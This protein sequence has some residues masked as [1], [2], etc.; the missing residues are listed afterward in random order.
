MELFERNNKFLV[1]SSIVKAIYYGIKL[2]N[3]YSFSSQLYLATFLSLAASGLIFH[4]IENSNLKKI[5]QE[6]NELDK[7][8]EKI[9][10]LREEINEI[11]E[12]FLKKK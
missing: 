1:G 6:L 2:F 7:C 12:T 10:M 8:S 11:Y 4:S 9:N 3:K 5:T